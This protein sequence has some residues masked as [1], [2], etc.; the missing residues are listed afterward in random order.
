M[1]G[2]PPF[3]AAPI[4]G[5]SIRDNGDLGIDLMPDG[6]V[7][8]VTANDGLGDPDTG[9][10]GLQNFP[11][12][13]AVAAVG[14]VDLG[15]RQPRLRR[16]DDLPDRGLRERRGRIRPATARAPSSTAAST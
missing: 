6:L 13:D 14:A 4:L 11:V 5:N 10:N 12:L 7:T 2:G 8:G 16:V 9:G 1:G 15:A 3:A